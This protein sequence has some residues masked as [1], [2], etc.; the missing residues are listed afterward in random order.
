MVFIG[1]ILGTREIKDRTL[2]HLGNSYWDTV[3]SG[4]TGGKGA[5]HNF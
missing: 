1:L 3:D 4:V 2:T 5:G